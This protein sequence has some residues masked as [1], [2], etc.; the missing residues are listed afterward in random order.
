MFS[1]GNKV[2]DLIAAVLDTV[3]GTLKH[4]QSSAEA[5]F[6]DLAW[7]INRQFRRARAT[8]ATSDVQFI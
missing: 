8:V 6:T 3:R 4:Q 7:W 1:I 5:H 2:R